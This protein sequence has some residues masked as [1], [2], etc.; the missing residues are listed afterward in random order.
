MK[1]LTM[2]YSLSLIALSVL[3]ATASAQLMVTP[4]QAKAAG[5]QVQPE[6]VPAVAVPAVA[7]PGLAP[8]ARSAAPLVP[9]NA[10]QGAEAEKPAPQAVK[11][12]PPVKKTAE[13]LVSTTGGDAATA[14]PVA[15]AVPLDEAAKVDEVMQKILA[16]QMPQQAP[17][18]APV[19]AA[20]NDE[21]TVVRGVTEIIPVS[22]NSMTH[23]TVPFQTPIVMK[24]ARTAIKV[25]S[26]PGS[27]FVSM[28]DERAGIYIYDE[29]DPENVMSIQLQPRD[30]PQRDIKLGFKVGSGARNKKAAEFEQAQPYTQTLGLL[31]TEVAQGK[32]PSGYSFEKAKGY[33]VT[34]QMEGMQL[35]LAQVMTGANFQIGV[36]SVRNASNEVVEV[37]EQ[38]CGQDKAVAVAAYPAAML[39]PGETTEL[40]VVKK[41]ATS[42]DGSERPAVN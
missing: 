7:V 33:E 9:V 14:A 6:R 41:I 18:A 34:C 38:S 40:Y 19:T 39:N 26:A 30:I 15:P 25:K 20:T 3:S 8:K 27:I 42:A 31:L 2:K 37:D 22:Q 5:I 11:K 29:A 23:L 17:A 35:K 28:G 21:I 36:F 1:E 16:S 24:D 10:S 12:L 32:I 13:K 4:E